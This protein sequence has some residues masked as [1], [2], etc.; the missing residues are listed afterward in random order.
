MTHV[1]DTVY[2]GAPITNIATF[3]NGGFGFGPGVFANPYT[4]TPLTLSATALVA[5]YTAGG[6]GTL[7]LAAGTGITA[8]V[9]ADGTTVYQFDVPRSI[10]F[11]SSGNISAVNFVITGY[12]VYGNALSETIAGP[13]NNTVNTL[14]AFYQVASITNSAAVGTATTVGYGDK[15][16]LPLKVTNTG[17]ILSLSWANALTRDAG[18]FV[19]GSTTAGLD[20]RGTYTPS[21][22]SNGTRVL[23]IVLSQTIAQ[24]SGSSTDVIGFNTT[25]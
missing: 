15:F 6:A 11:T 16:G 24:L 9:R 17:Q 1:S 14:Q 21:S 3:N 23:Y 8:V 12:D 4:I 7:T 25:P 13:N 20:S 2:Q 19:A 5:T 18:T 10:S 22:A